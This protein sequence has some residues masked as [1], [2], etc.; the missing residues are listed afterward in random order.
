MKRGAMLMALV[1]CLSTLVVHSQTLK[2]LQ[3]KIPDR[4]DRLFAQL[5]ADSNYISYLILQQDAVSAGKKYMDSLALQGQKEAN[6]FSDTTGQHA[7]FIQEI[8]RKLQAALQLK[9]LLDKQYPLLGQLSY[10]EE[11]K[12][13]R[14][15]VDYYQR[16]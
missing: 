2:H 15:S 11:T 12:L 13:K 10:S 1:F 7:P 8:N 5:K 3:L 6:I 9:S 14:L 16:Q 4:V